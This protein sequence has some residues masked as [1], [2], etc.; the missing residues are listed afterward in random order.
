MADSSEK[1]AE[2]L[3]SEGQKTLE[4]FR[5]LGSD[6][7][8]A[9]IYTDEATWRV[10]DV[11]A[12]FLATEIN[13]LRLVQNILAG[14]GGSPED[15]RLDEYNRRKVNELADEAV[16]ILMQRFERQR[17]ETAGFVRRLSDQDLAATGRH[18]F[19]G[20]A[21]V[22]EILRLMYRHNQIHQR[23]IRR[24]LNEGEARQAG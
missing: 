6:D 23:D 12:H 21:P 17:S 3:H 9:Q 1:L 13:M 2:R 22:E 7:W 15:F 18:P 10:R 8:Q 16:E 19:L 5:G 4:F 11:L 20:I 14:R 24:A